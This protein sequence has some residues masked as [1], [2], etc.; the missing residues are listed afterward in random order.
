MHAIA[1]LRSFPRMT[2]ADPIAWLPASLRG[3]ALLEPALLA[4]HAAQRIITIGATRR[5]ELVWES[6]SALDYVSEV[7][8]D[9]ESAIRELIRDQLPQAEIIGEEYSPDAVA[10]DGLT[11]VVDPLDGTTNFLHG[12]PWYAISIGVL[13]R[14]VLVAGVVQNAATGECFVG[15]Q[16]GGAWRRSGATAEQISVSRITDPAHALIGTGFPFKHRDLIEPYLAQFARIAASTAGMRRP[17]AAALDLCDV[18][19][20]RFEAFWELRLAP[21]D[22][23]AG[24]CIVREA[25]GR[26]SD[27]AGTDAKVI[28]GPIVASNGTLHD[29]L[30]E[31]LAGNT[32][33]P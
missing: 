17:G 11:F 21:W 23:A 33:T 20:G 29:W 10:G 19:C 25:G 5:G 31:T 13:D 18:A 30:L 26:V 8:R 1:A 9:A 27:L 6:K 4:A 3:D 28:G 16:G 15:R 2:D 22:I 7:D 24:I 12:F 32:T 14:G